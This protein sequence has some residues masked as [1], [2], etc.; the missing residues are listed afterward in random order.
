MSLSVHGDLA[1]GAALRRT[2]TPLSQELDRLG[3]ELITG[4]SARPLHHLSGDLAP[5][6]GIEHR[7]ATLAPQAGNLAA[8]GQHLAAQQAALGRLADEGGTVGARLSSAGTAG[9]PGPIQVAGQAARLAF[10][11]AVGVLNTRLAGQSLFAGAAPDG[12][13]LA[14]A[15]DIL[16]AALAATAGAASPGAL[17]AALRDW[18]ADPAGFEAAAWRGAAPDPGGPRPT[19]DTRLGETVTARE[20]G[21]AGHLAALAAGAALAEGRFAGNPEAERALALA[22]GIALTGAD[23]GLVAVRARLGDAEA[24][25]DAAVTRTRFEADALERARADLVGVDPYATA[26]RMEALRTALEKTYLVTARLS[27]LSL[28]EYLR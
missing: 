25:V 22:A 6:A 27:R 9:L 11:D 26:S 10:D 18:F 13:A 14:P 1:A 5:L 19:P 4:R 16:A 21:I 12:P 2:A 24:R 20:A 3:V 15:G 8:L 28:A 7:L 17:V 23:A